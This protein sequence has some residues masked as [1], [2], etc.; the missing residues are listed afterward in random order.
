MRVK[1]KIP[2]IISLALLALTSCDGEIS[3]QTVINKDGSCS[4]EISFSADSL[5]LTGGGFNEGVDK[6]N[7]EVNIHHINLNDEWAMAWAVR[8]EHE[9]HPFPMSAEQ[10]NVLNEELKPAGRSVSDTVVVYAQRDFATVGD[11]CADTPLKF[12]GKPLAVKGTLEKK[13]C[14][15]Y[16]DYCYTE[17]YEC[18]ADNFTIPLSE[19]FKSEDE[20]SYWLTGYPN[21][22]EGKTPAQSSDYMNNW[23]K[24]YEEWNKANI[25]SD[26]FDYIVENYGTIENPS[27]TKKEFI[28]GRQRFIYA[29]LQ[30][31]AVARDLG[32]VLTE[33]YGNSYNKIVNEAMEQE[34][35]L[36]YGSLIM[37]DF[38]ERISMP[39]KVIDAGRGEVKDGM[40]VYKISA[41]RLLPGEYVV[42]VKSRVPNVWA[43][44][45]SALAA[46]TPFLLRLRK[47]K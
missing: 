34:E 1:S 16:T 25:A 30:K 8:G 26:V 36:K 39:G 42:E 14:W 28:A 23:Q 35:C 5:Y 32:L 24:C 2:F 31:E 43:F 45:V 6:E 22:R 15:F 41:E 40:V 9:R 11:M 47:R 37:L 21:L 44:V 3:M 27:V 38:K 20:A 10:Y 46:V 17:V 33:L 18:I 4:R 29:C 19:Y 7:S 13:F 12:N